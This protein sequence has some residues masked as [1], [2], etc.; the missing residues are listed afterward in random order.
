[1]FV[2]FLSGVIYAIE[3]DIQ[4]IDQKFSYVHSYISA[5]GTIDLDEDEQEDKV[6]FPYFKLCLN[7]L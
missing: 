5:V 6:W 2:D 1:M 3:G 4:R 7:I